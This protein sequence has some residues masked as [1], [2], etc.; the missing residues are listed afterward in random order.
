MLPD[1]GCSGTPGSRDCTGKF[2]ILTDSFHR[3]SH[4]SLWGDLVT[5]WRTEADGQHVGLL[6]LGSYPWLILEPGQSG[7][8]VAENQK[9][10]QLWGD[11]FA[12]G[13]QPYKLRVYDPGDGSFTHLWSFD[14]TIMPIAFHEEPSL[15]SVGFLQIDPLGGIG[16][17]YCDT[18]MNCDVNDAVNLFQADL[19]KANLH[20][21][22]LNKAS[23]REAILHGADLSRTVLYGAFLQR[24]TLQW[25][26][27]YGANLTN[28]DLSEADLQEANLRGAGLYGASLREADLQKADLRAADLQQ[29]DL[30]A[31]NLQEADLQQTDLRGA[32]LQQANL[33]GVNLEGANL[34]KADLKGATMPD[35][36]VHS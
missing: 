18:T 5:F 17:M 15:T 23:L 1:V 34:K 13:A 21:A 20:K 26:H 2:E 28:S 25:A 9:L 29:A 32:H 7:F 30:E 24:A 16:V 6:D 11:P 12:G 3:H 22:Y 27:L 10:L 36:T 4:C 14:S 19:Q 33:M 31:A 35:G 8:P